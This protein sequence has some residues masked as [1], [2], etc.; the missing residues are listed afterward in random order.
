MALLGPAAA[1]AFWK[2]AK[3]NAPP[4]PFLEAITSEQGACIDEWRFWG[5]PRQKPS[6]N[7]QSQ[8]EFLTVLILFYYIYRN[9]SIL[10]FLVKITPRS[11]G[12]HAET[13]RPATSPLP[14]GHCAVAPQP[15]TCPSVPIRVRASQIS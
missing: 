4:P 12:R 11:H 8:M 7:W 15:A 14:H 9:S 13:P 3:S 2:L 5:L 10:N 1:K 6:G